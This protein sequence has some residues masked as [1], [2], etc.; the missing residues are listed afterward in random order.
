M[1]MSEKFGAAKD[2]LWPYP[3]YTGPGGLYG[4]DLGLGGAVEVQP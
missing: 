2:A 1:A 4:T 3:E